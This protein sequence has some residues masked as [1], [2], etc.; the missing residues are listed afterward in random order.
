MLGR[1]R[2]RLKMPGLQ[3][4]SA[5]WSLTFVRQAL[6]AVWSLTFVRHDRLVAKQL[7]FEPSLLMQPPSNRFG[8]LK[9]G[10]IYVMRAEEFKYV[11]YIFVNECLE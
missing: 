1:M 7:N 4:L 2:G 5:V 8:Q 9:C 3:A 6:S 11:I 10:V